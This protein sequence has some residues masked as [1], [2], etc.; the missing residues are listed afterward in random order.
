MRNP[1]LHLFYYGVTHVISVACCIYTALIPYLAEYMLHLFLY[2]LALSSLHPPT[3]F[4]LSCFTCF[5][6][7]YVFCV[8]EKRSNSYT[9]LCVYSTVQEFCAVQ[10]YAYGR[11]GLFIHRECT[12]GEELHE[13]RGKCRE[14]RMKTLP[15]ITLQIRAIESGDTPSLVL[16]RSVEEK[17]ES[18]FPYQTPRN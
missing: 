8:S 17:E 9:V 14:G 2:F 7:Y 13:R 1:S 4:L 10:V 5:S 12:G 6:S 3:L 16:R 11:V 15:K 18:S